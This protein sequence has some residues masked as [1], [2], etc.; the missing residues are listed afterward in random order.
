MKDKICDMDIRKQNL[1][2]KPGD[3]LDEADKF[4]DIPGGKF[5]LEK[6]VMRQKGHQSAG[7]HS[8]AHMESIKHSRPYQPV[9]KQNQKKDDI[10]HF[11]P[12]HSSNVTSF[13]MPLVTT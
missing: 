4:H 7:N 13:F 6:E 9:Q 10:T 2:Q 1:I 12:L 8:H 11:K 5:L 3:I